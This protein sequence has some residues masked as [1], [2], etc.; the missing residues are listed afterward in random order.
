MQLAKKQK[1]TNSKTSSSL[2]HR[3][4]VGIDIGQHA[5]KMVQLSGRSLNQ[6]QLEKGQ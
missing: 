5:I 4:A 3:S 2:S 6:I 1:N